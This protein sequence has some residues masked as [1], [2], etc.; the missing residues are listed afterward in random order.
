MDSLLFYLALANAAIC[1]IV[2]IPL[3]FGMLK[4]RK[5]ADVAWPDDR[6]L[7]R[8]SV[9]VAARN[10]ERNIEEGLRSLLNLDY[11]DLQIIVVDDRSTDGT[12][13]ILDRLAGE[14]ERLEVVHLNELPAGW[15]GKN[16]A[17]YY[18]AER[19]DGEVIL[20]TDADVVLQPCVLRRAV[21]YMLDQDVDHLPILFRVR[22]PNWLLESFVVTFSVYL[23]AHFRPWKSP[24]PDSRAHIGVGGFNLVR[25]DVYR[26][27][28]T[29][30]AIRMRP[31]DDMKFG[32]LV[33]KHRFR[34][35]LLNG[36]DL[37]YVPWYGSLRELV[38]GL[39][40]NAFSG[41]DYNIFFA[42]LATGSML[43]F[44]VFPFFALFFARGVSWWIYLAV[45]ASLLLM[46]LGAAYHGRARLSCCLG[47]PLAAAMMV[48]I[49]WRTIIV[50]LALGGIRWR[51]TYYSLSELKANKV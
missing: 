11:D 43:A 2:G 25:R 27:I 10:E 49:T 8:A 23:M 14:S 51:D 4:I 47:F 30:Q 22:M 45:V 40:K 37:M 21:A 36:T 28:G 35:E 15:L 16:H 29:Y 19:A 12:G 33:K 9:I 5:L 1:A 13:A 6:P 24:D 38:V 31:D 41:V 44:N 7:P 3:F 26:A 39:E 18:G 48:L 46:A 34:Q 50:N 32:K 20:F 42:L 17:L